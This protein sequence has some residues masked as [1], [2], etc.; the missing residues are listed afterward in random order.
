MRDTENQVNAVG[1]ISLRVEFQKLSS[2]QI[3]IHLTHT[4]IYTEG[5]ISRDASLK[6]I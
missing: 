4:N 5:K 6:K 1:V 3:E 2:F